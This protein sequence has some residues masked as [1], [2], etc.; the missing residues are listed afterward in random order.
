MPRKK[1]APAATAA[2]SRASAVINKLKSKYPGRVFTAGEYTMPWKVKR[3]PTGVLDLDIAL[4]GGLPAGGMSFFTGKQG[5]GKNWLANQVIR[6]HQ[7]QHGEK[8]SVAVVSTEMVFDKEFAHACGVKVSFSDL[9][10]AHFI[11]EYREDLL[12]DPSDEIVGA[13]TEQIG[14]FATIPPSTAEEALQIAIDVIASREFDIVV[15]DSFGSL[16]TEHDNVGELGDSPRVGGAAMLNTRFARKLNTALSPDKDGNPNLTCVIGINQVRDNT[17]RANKYSPKTLEAG[18]WALKHAR[19]VTVEMAPQAKIKDGKLLTGK[20]IRW[21]I[22]KQ[23]AGGHEGA[24]GTF[25][26]MYE[27][28]G[29]DREAHSVAVAGDYGIVTRKG[30]WYSYEGEQIGQGARAAAEFVRE[31]DGLL[32]LLEKKTLSAAGVRCSYG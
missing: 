20:T 30:A 26:F 31:T 32:E 3:L 15:I 13:L 6:E 23:K 10:V 18:G 1:K 21:E 29:I 22:T 11:S 2:G 7:R 8:T 19:W 25:D 17:D 12:E 14:E 4:G 27:H 24:R 28:C 9:E 5:V 16:L